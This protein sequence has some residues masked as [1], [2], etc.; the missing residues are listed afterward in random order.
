LR[1]DITAVAK[2]ELRS[3][4]ILG[5]MMEAAGVVFLDRANREKAI[6]ALLPAVDTLKAGKSIAI[7]P[8]GTRSRDY[9][10]GRFKKGAFHLAMQA[11][12]PVV[13]IVIKNAYEVMP[14]GTNVFRPGA[15]EVVVLPPVPTSDWQKETINEH[16]AEVRAMYLRELNQTE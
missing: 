14:R 8:E 13:P 16:I 15:V 5:Q 2:K 4:P 7:A 6:A 10:L 9:R 3:T 1:R 11:G 12:V